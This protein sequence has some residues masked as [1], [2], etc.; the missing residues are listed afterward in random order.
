MA[1]APTRALAAALAGSSQ[2]FCFYESATQRWRLTN[3]QILL[4]LVSK[5]TQLPTL[6][7]TS[8]HIIDWALVECH[9]P[10][11]SVGAMTCGL[12]P[13][14]EGVGEYVQ[15]IAG[16]WF[17]ISLIGR[18]LMTDEQIENHRTNCMMMLL[19]L[20]LS[21]LTAYLYIR[22]VNVLGVCNSTTP[23]LLEEEAVE[24]TA[25][26]FAEVL[27]SSFQAHWFGG[28]EIAV[29]CYHLD[30]KYKVFYPLT[31]IFA[32]TVCLEIMCQLGGNTNCLNG[33]KIIQ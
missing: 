13:R 21:I 14:G 31:Y 32:C 23:G 27:T 26:G 4:P 2:Y 28:C 30:G 12:E 33:E 17:S 15:R 22:G 16:E 24:L 9:H 6:K 5:A 20:W 18:A 1:D 10:P 11:V 19:A 29:Q 8:N 3:A 7:I 25:F